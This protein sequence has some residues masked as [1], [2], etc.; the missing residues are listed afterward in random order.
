VLLIS[1]SHEQEKLRISLTILPS[2]PVGA[3]RRTSPNHGPLGSSKI[4][5]FTLSLPAK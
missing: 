2:N 3:D 4:E 5:E 1:L